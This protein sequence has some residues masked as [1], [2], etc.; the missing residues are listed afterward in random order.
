MVIVMTGI[1]IPLYEQSSGRLRGDLRLDTPRDRKWM[2]FTNPRTTDA[3]TLQD[4]L[5][6]WHDGATLPEQKMTALIAVMKN[7]RHLR[8]LYGLLQELDLTRSPVLI[9]DDE[10]DQASMNTK[11]NQSDEST[12]YQRIGDI[13]SACPH[14]TFLQYTA[15]PQAPLLISIIDA[16]SPNFVQILEPG[17]GYVGGQELF[18]EHRN[19]HI[20]PIPDHELAT[21]PEDAD[22]PPDS[23]LEALRVFLLGVAASYAT[24]AANPGGNRSM[25]VHPSH[26]TT[27]HSVYYGWVQRVK[28]QWEDHLRRP[29][30]DAACELL[31]EF[32]SAY[33]VLRTTEPTIPSFDHLAQHLPRAIRLTQVLEVNASRGKTPPIPWFN[34]YSWI[35]VAGQ[36]VDRGFTV[37]GL[38]VTYMPRGVGVGNADTLQQRGRFFGYKYPYLGY[39]RIYLPADAADAYHNYVE[40]E[41]NV[42][43]QL[44]EYEAPGRTL[45]EWKRAFI[46]ASAMRPTRQNVLRLDYMRGQLINDWFNPAYPLASEEVHQANRELTQSFLRS[47]TLAPDEGHPERTA[48]QTHR[49]AK[50]IT[51]ERVLGD[52]L[53]PLRVPASMDAQRFTGLMLQLRR[54]LDRDPEEL[55]DFYQMSPTEAR[56]RSVNEEGRIPNLFQGEYPVNPRNVR[57]SIYPGDRE[58]HAPNRVT[59]Q[60]HM[61]T[62]TDKEDRSIIA[63]DVPIVAVWVPSRL[64]AAWIVQD[65]DT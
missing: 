62:L 16:L 39:C 28:Q 10:A 17:A 42:R 59:L 48:T 13:R 52:L 26:R 55:C 11:V 47:M 30:S 15:T 3:R 19:T 8:N 61:V 51:L 63:A 45:D 33:D 12:T 34:A 29:D 25:L 14:H 21:D 46:M 60:L 31:E 40:H 50:G 44:H 5:R 64:A 54:A 18:I 9:I 1:S 49:V 23:L 2:L 20:C 56:R 65:D 36:A 32:R 53:V 4:L 58:I 6:D 7:H 22:G 37:E 27:K 57:G 43:S 35:I 24:S 38:T 41:E